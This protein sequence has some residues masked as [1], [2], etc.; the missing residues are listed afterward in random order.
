MVNK[1]VKLFHVFTVPQSI[2]F[3]QGQPAYMRK[4]GIETHVVC[5]PG[6]QL[7]A[8]AVE[9]SV[10]AHSIDIPRDLHLWRGLRAVI[11]MVRL[12][13]QEKPDIVDAH[14]PQ[15]GVMALVAAKLAGVPIRIYHMRGLP[16]LSAHG[17]L[18]RF[19]MAT[20]WL[21]GHLATHTLVVSH[22]NR[23]IA[24]AQGFIR[25]DNSSVIGAGSG[26]GVDLGR[27]SPKRVD[28]AAVAAL[29]ESLGIP[30]G[31]HIVGYVGRIA[32]EKGI[33]ELVLAWESIAATH[34]DWHLVLWG[35][36]EER[37]P[38]AAHIKDVIAD[39][40]S[41]H[42][43]GH[44]RDMVTAYGLADIIVL[45]TYREGFPNVALEAAA[46]ARPIVATWSTGCMDAVVHN[47]SGI[48][49]PVGDV[50]SLAKA[51]VCYI[52]D[53]ALREVHGAN[54]RQRVHALFSRPEV[55]DGIYHVYE[56][57]LNKAGAE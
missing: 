23:M 11:Q 31:H 54:A 19:L 22:S 5:S 45:P 1:P 57:L 15:A 3:I 43:A 50:D 56:G 44:C 52:D 28:A 46:M 41:I 33:E 18:R 40:P 32:K 49:V 53:S 21:S 26:Q 42:L 51:L 12:F 38:L 39:N 36:I 35:R 14:T 4:R 48:L 29:R 17:L 37:R 13:Q 6:E 24:L 20:E 47:Y 2:A 9:E 10:L 16:F 8:F 30:V 25:E 34:P 27:F 55:I 7:D